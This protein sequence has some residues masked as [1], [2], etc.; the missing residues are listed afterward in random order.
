MSKLHTRM[1]KLLAL[2]EQGVGGERTNAQRMLTS[3]MEKYGI[4]LDE[5][6]GEEKEYHYWNYDSKHERTMLFQVLFKV[7]NNAEFTY[8]KGDRKA[9]FELTKAEYIE[10]DLQYT[11]LRKELKRH[12]ERAVNAFIQANELYSDTVT[13]EERKYSAAELEELRAMLRMAQTITPTAVNKQ[14]TTD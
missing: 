1:R 5:L 6:E 10:V 3:M 7:L 13:D 9:G 12:I 14:L 11:T 8:R 2:A 4:T